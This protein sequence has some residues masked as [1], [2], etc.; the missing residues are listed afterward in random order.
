MIINKVSYLSKNSLIK[1]NIENDPY[2]VRVEFF[3][4]LNLGEGDEINFKEFKKVINEN[5]FNKAKDL[6]LKKI[7]KSQKTT[8]DIKLF[9][10]K[11]GYDSFIIGRILDFLYEY[12]LVNDE[13]FARNYISDKSNINKWPKNKIIYKLKQKGISDSI[14]D[15]Y[16]SQID[17]DYEYDLARSLAIKKSNSNFSFENKQKVYRYLANKGFSYD[18]V[19]EVIGELF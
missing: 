14:I 16:I 7:S 19:S 5:S 1:L 8:Y 4:D 3:N 6:A 12:N 15:E 18:I 13:E 11:E 17:E 10:Q 2:L 9:L